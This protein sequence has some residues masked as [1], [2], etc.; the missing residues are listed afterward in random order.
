MH[1]SEHKKNI[2]KRG[3]ALSAI[4]HNIRVFSPEKKPK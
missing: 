2:E 3:P 1:L 4:E